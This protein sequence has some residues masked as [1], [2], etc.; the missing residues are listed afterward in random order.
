MVVF[1]VAC[2]HVQSVVGSELAGVVGAH[3]V[4]GGC[5]VSGIGSPAGEYLIHMC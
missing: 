4:H 3:V 2:A 5:V 1:S